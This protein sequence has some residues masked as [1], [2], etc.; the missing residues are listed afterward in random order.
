MAHKFDLSQYAKIWDSKEGRL[1]TSTILRDP[2]MLRSN[3]GFW[4]QKFLVDPNI[5]PTDHEGIATFRSTMRK[6]ETGTLGHLR[7]PM[8]DTILK[9]RGNAAFYT[10]VIPDFT[11]DGFL[12]T[13]ETRLY[14]EKMYESF[15]NDASLI[16]GYTQDVLQPMVDG[17]NMTVSHM[18]A[19]LMSTGKINY[20][21]GEGA[22]M[23][24]LKADIP[25]ENFLKA[26]VAVWT[27]AGCRILD[28]WRALV[29]KV[30]DMLGIEDGTIQW[31]LEITRNMWVNTVLKNAQVIEWVRYANSLNN[32]LLPQNLE[33][34]TDMATK[35]LSSFEGLPQIVLIQEKQKDGTNG[36]VHGWNDNTAVLR[37]VG[38]A[39]YIR[40]TG[41]LDEEV[42]KRFANNAIQFN[43]SKT[44][45]GLLT[46]MNSV[47]PSGTLKEWHT[48]P[49]YSCIPSLDEFLYHFI[50][51]TAT[52]GV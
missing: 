31:Q 23:R 49:M 20:Q 37:P 13:A 14:K 1:I 48:Q 24:L 3:F 26:G 19:Q 30:N 50:I 16:A 28:Q 45:S 33:I 7:A 12:E 9:E 39:G 32:V 2:E 8:G 27:A 35:A 47:V 21:Q 5:T 52:A 22:Q 46:I 15:G 10:G 29:Q 34:T 11:G 51:D 44:E 18:A 38:Y 6:I 4:K 25:A 41:I 42:Y 36:I 17:F 43:F 40:H